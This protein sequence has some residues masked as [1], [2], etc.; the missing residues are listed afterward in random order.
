MSCW[1]SI[2]KAESIDWLLEEDN[3][4]IRYWALKDLLD[5]SETEP[6]VAEAK[7]KICESKEVKM[8]FSKSDI[9]GGP[10]WSKPNGNIYWG[11][12]STGSALMFLAETGL[13]KED[14]GIE[15]LARLLFR[16]QSA[17]G[18]FKLSPE[19]PG[20]WSCFTATVLGALLRFGYVDDKTV[21]KGIEWL[22]ST[23]RLDG[24]WY[25]TKNALKGGPK[26]KLDS[27][28]H[29]VLNVLWAFMNTP[30]LRSRKELVPAVEFLLHHWEIKIPIPD[31]DR[32][33]Y[34]IGSR[35]GWIKYPLFEYHLLKYVYVLSHYDYALK[36]RRLIEAI[37]LLISKQDTQGRWVIDKP[38]TGWEEFEFGKK[39]CPS[40]WATLNAL[41]VLK[42]LYS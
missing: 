16:Y 25:C 6:E 21:E 1:K 9:N 34:G 29:S 10:F 5:K 2:L 38:Y 11:T 27:C 32:G 28:P 20:W 19:G 22:L 7:G 24:G 18:F 8:I 12:F 36:D 4:S 3:P 13:T 17:E 37:D 14:T 30:E 31:V 33:R 15:G 39:G 23:Q 26:E 35:F 42:R 41:R 40:K